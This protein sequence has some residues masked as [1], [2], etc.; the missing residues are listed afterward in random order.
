MAASGIQSTG[1]AALRRDLGRVDT[2]LVVELR[3][4]LKTAAEPVRARAAQLAPRGTGPVPKS[5]R[6]VTGARSRQRLSTSL[7]VNVRGVKV[8][9]RSNLAYAGI[10]HW[11]GR[12]PANQD[13]TKWVAVKGRPFI[14]QAAEQKADETLDA[15]ADGV[16]RLLKRNGFS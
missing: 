13:R 6:T 10:V 2:G 8:V 11:G 3:K 4:E 5:R 12:R 14:A 7:R 9:V 15:L 1:M 16:D